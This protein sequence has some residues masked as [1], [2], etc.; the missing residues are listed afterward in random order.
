VRW[1]WIV[2]LGVAVAV[3]TFVYA[4]YRGGDAATLGLLVVCK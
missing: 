3:A 4:W 1:W 2:L